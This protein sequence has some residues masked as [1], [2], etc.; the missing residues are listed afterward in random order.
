MSPDTTTADSPTGQRTLHDSRGNSLDVRWR[1]NAEKVLVNMDYLDPHGRIYWTSS[2][3]LT[4][5][6]PRWTFTVPPAGNRPGKI[7][8]TAEDGQ[9]VLGGD[10]PVSAYGSFREEIARWQRPSLSTLST[11]PDEPGEV[12]ENAPGRGWKPAGSIIRNPAC[13]QELLRILSVRPP[14]S[15]L[16]GGPLP[17]FVTL[18]HPEELPFYQE[19][20]KLRAEP[21]GW[22][23]M[24]AA[25]AKFAAQDP[26]FIQ[27]LALDTPASAYPLLSPSRSPAA[28]PRAWRAR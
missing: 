19:L 20:A 13:P 6:L 12:A 25:A 11:I 5:R 17:G 18:L 24:I 2:A 16:P 15:P 3:E 28:P 4:E 1:A 22:P 23:Q 21:G 8:L 9:F 27:S 26:A 10:L 7:E 14:A